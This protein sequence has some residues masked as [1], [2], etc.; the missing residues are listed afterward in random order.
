L[1]PSGQ[2]GFPRPVHKI[3]STSNALQPCTIEDE[4]D[5]EYE[6]DWPGGSPRRS[7]SPSGQIQAPGKQETEQNDR[8]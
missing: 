4:D 7:G 5:D 8:P 6:D 1:V 3:G 2:N